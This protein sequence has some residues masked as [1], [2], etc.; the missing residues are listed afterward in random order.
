VQ[1][2]P[3]GDRHG[4]GHAEHGLEG[5][6]GARA[7]HVPARGGRRGSPARRRARARSARCARRALAGRR[8]APL[9]VNTYIHT[10]HALSPKG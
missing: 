8:R 1:R 2:E 6:A 4:A 5:R 9:T 7:R 3:G 10:T